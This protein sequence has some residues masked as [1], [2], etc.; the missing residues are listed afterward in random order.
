MNNLIMIL[1]AVLLNLRIIGIAEDEG[2]MPG[3]LKMMLVVFILLF[4]WWVS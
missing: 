4:I 3:L 1:A 2:G